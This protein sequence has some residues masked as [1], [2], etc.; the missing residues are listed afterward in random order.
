MARLRRSLAALNW[1]AGGEDV[2]EL[3]ALAALVAGERLATPLTLKN[4]ARLQ[5]TPLTLKNTAS[6]THTLI[7]NKGS[8]HTYS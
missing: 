5:P 8:V 4:T 1:A 7:L 3:S 6:A 2:R